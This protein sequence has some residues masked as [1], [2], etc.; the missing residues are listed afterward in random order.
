M[1]TEK[2]KHPQSYVPN[3]NKNEVQDQQHTQETDSCLFKRARQG[4]RTRQRNNIFNIETVIY[5]RIK[6]AISSGSKKINFRP[7]IV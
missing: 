7:D 1:R 4:K 2:E 6:Q 5:N 3:K